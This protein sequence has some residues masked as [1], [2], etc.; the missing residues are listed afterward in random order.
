MISESYK[1]SIF[2]EIKYNYCD[3]T[4]QQE[5]WLIWKRAKGTLVRDPPRQPLFWNVYVHKIV[6]TI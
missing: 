6:G 5:M 1:M 2:L 3:Q 4:F